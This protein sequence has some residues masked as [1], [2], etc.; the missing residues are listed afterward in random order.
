MGIN[1]FNTPH[2][3]RL[4]LVGGNQIGYDGRYAN[5]TGR[6]FIV[7]PAEFIQAQRVTTRADEALVG[8]AVIVPTPSLLSALP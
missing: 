8:A 1:I 5:P 6:A 4:Q 3:V 2:P 7:G